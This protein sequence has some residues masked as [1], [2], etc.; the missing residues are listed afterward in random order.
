MAGPK[1][2]GVGAFRARRVEE[3]HDPHVTQHDRLRSVAGRNYV[4]LATSAEC[5]LDRRPSIP[6]IASIIS[7]I[8]TTS[9]ATS[10]VTYFLSTGV[11]LS[12][13]GQRSAVSGQAMGGIICKFLFRFRKCLILA[14]CLSL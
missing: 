6:S 8:S 11:S 5:D 1:V 14:F 10:D 4:Q 7:R 13:S 2:A 12:V 9:S 3:P